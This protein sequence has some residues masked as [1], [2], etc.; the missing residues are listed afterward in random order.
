METSW[1]NYMGY[2]N[3]CKAPAWVQD[4]KMIDELKYDYKKYG[5]WEK[6]VAAHLAPSLAWNKALWNIRIGS[7]PSVWNYVKKVL[8]DSNIAINKPLL[9]CYRVG[10]AN[11]GTI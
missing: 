2:K 11:T 4:S 1:N 3:P 10:Y 7:N 5:D 8:K 6:V 9:Y